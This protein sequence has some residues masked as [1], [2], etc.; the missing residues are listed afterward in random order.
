MKISEAQID[1][2][3]KDMADAF[4]EQLVDH[5]EALYAPVARVA[6]RK[7]MRAAADAALRAAGARS[8]T[9][10]PNARSYWDLTLLLG[11][12]FGADPVLSRF[13]GIVEPGA[14]ERF[15]RERE[16]E[17]T[18]D[19]DE[20]DPDGL[21]I[22]PTELLQIVWDAGWAWLDVAAGENFRHLY[23]ACA[24]LSVLLGERPVAPPDER[25]LVAALERIYPEKARACRED[26]IVAF[27]AQAR[28]RI[29]KAGFDDPAAIANATLFSFIGGV[30][31]ISDQAFSLDGRQIAQG[32]EGDGGALNAAM[33]DYLRALVAAARAEAAG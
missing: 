20:M 5:A 14:Q 13:S 24:R 23:A 18:I 7:Q 27:L 30:G 21:E 17:M 8:F 10:R 32:R 31:A 3:G 12:E 4:G 22:D 25:A 9:T 15:F 1:K 6:G 26:E 33:A 16:A 28:R 11:A 2:L 19:G 29:V